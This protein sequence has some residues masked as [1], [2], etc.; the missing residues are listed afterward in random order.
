[1]SSL[2]PALSA[3]FEPT[4]AM[5]HAILGAFESG[6]VELPINPP[7]HAPYPLSQTFFMHSPSIC[8]HGDV[9]CDRV[10]KCVRRGWPGSTDRTVT[11]TAVCRVSHTKVA[12]LRTLSWRD[13]LGCLFS[14]CSSI[15]QFSFAFCFLEIG[16]HFSFTDESTF[17]FSLS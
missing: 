13:V 11:I 5:W 9:E 7:I 15:K 2:L 3:A 1:M 4:E 10:R 6:M 17:L 12:L 14:I 16:F 8:H